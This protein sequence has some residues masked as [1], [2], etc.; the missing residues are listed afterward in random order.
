MKEDQLENIK[1]YDPL[2]QEVIKSKQ[3]FH[4]N[5]LEAFQEIKKIENQDEQIQIFKS[6]LDLM[7]RQ[8]RILKIIFGNNIIRSIAKLDFDKQEDFLRYLMNRLDFFTNRHLFLLYETIY[9]TLSLLNYKN[10]HEAQ[11]F[12]TREFKKF[13]QLVSQEM[14]KSHRTINHTIQDI[15]TKYLIN[16]KDQLNQLINKK[17]FL[18]DLNLILNHPNHFSREEIE[19]FLEIARKN[20]FPY[21]IK[22]FSKKEIQTLY[23]NIKKIIDRYKKIRTYDILY[24]ITI[25]GDLLYPIKIQEKRLA[26]LTNCLT[27]QKNEINEEYRP[28]CAFCY[29]EKIKDFPEKFYPK[30]SAFEIFSK[31]FDEAFKNYDKEMGYI[32]LEIE[33]PFKSPF[34]VMDLEAT[35]EQIINKKDFITTMGYLFGSKAYIY[36]LVDFGKY[37]QFYQVIKKQSYDFKRPAVAYNFFGSERVWLRLRNERGWIDIQRK[38]RAFSENNKEYANDVKLEQI[39]FEW[40]DISGKDCIEECRLYQQDGDLHHLKK[41]SYHNFFD[42]LREYLI[43]LTDLLIHDYLH[44]KYYDLLTNKLYIRYYCPYCHF[45]FNSIKNLDNHLKNPSKECKK[46]QKKMKMQ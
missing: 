7:P 14:N 46:R 38:K 9:N 5:L 34:T 10:K 4:D 29:E 24:Y 44:G 2:I 28:L 45:G 32:I 21:I 23:N 3:N 42:L 25:R 11:N 6:L 35:G 36:Q 40:D 17:Q 15:K 19:Q 37:E 1:E 33:L 20:I 8:L 16:T 13:M 39:S 43:G 22:L 41:I 30:E 12:K 27:C 18:G 31:F 26:A